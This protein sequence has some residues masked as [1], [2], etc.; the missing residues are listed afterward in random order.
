M[1]ATPESIVRIGQ[2]GFGYWGPNLAR[3][4]RAIPA[5][6]L[7]A[8]CDAS[9]DRLAMAG[10]L[11]RSATLYT[12]FDEMLASEIDGVA[13]ATPARSHYPLVMQALKAGKHV[14]VEKPL[15]MTTVEAAEM[16]E[17][18]E[19][20]GRV[21]MV[22]H[23]FEYNPAVR[24][25]KNLLD[26]GAIGD[27]Y[28][29]YST[30]VNLG[31]IQSDINAL[32]SI[33]PH[34]IS[35]FLYLL[36]QTP[37]SVSARGAR[38]LSGDVED[39]V[40]CSMQFPSGVVAHVHASWLDPSKV[41]CMTVVGSHKMVVYDDLATEGKVKIYDKGVTRFTNPQY[42]EYQYRLHTGDIL[43]PKLTM[44]EPLRLE[45]EDF[46]RAIQTGESPL[47]DGRNGLRVVQVL[48]AAQRSME[49]NSQEIAINL[50]A[51]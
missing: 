35:I 8:L 6:E 10:D 18:A 40:F 1:S 27:V 14:F 33:A 25:V 42:G 13:I 51:A 38:Y 48:E 30:R 3:N 12:S 15:A 45:C 11:Y 36:G 37:E 5:C 28:Y 29:L 20:L 43:I 19:R 41:R 46:V 44:Q 16:V 26:S 24:Y 2:I 32:W 22:G 4:F 39:V 23:V 17:T 21:L 9:P 49:R 50:A 47:T 7:S 31:R 34:D